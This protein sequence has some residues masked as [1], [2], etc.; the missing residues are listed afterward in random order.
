MKWKECIGTNVFN[1][2]IVR[3][4]TAVFSVF[5]HFLGF[6]F[7]LLYADMHLTLKHCCSYFYSIHF[8]KLFILFLIIHI[9]RLSYAIFWFETI[10]SEHAHA[11]IL[12]FAFILSCISTRISEIKIDTSH[13]LMIF[14]GRCI[15]NL[16][17]WQIRVQFVFVCTHGR[18]KAI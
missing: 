13:L 14:T 8:F 11:C 18:K 10:Y 16:A 17:V 3:F 7:L 1:N 12:C 2:W 9:Y 5:N 15:R 4:N 6:G